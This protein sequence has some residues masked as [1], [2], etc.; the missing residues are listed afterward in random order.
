MARKFLYL[1]AILIALFVAAGLVFQLAPDKV[2][3]LAFVPSKPF[4]AP[5]ALPANRYADQKLWFARPGLASDPL[6][7]EP[8]GAKPA[9]P[10]KAAVFFIH[11]TSYLARADWNAPLDD[12]ESQDRARLFLRGLASPLGNAVQ[13]WAPRYRQAA[14]GAFFTDGPEGK[15]ALDAAYADVLAAFDQFLAEAPADLPIVLAGHSQ[16]GFHLR[17]LLAERVADQPIARRIAAVYAVGW[18]VSAEHDLPRMGLPACTAPDQSGCVASWLSYG[19]PYDAAQMAG[20]MA[21]YQGLD[22]QSL[23]GGRF[24]CWNPLT[25][26]LD[27]NAPAS[28]NLGTLVPTSDLKDGEIKPGYTPAGC[29]KDGTL[30]LGGTPKM[31]PYVLPGNNYHVYDMPLFWENLRADYARRVAAW[32]SKH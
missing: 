26:T 13:V 28:A 20:A 31:G 30:S 4:A 9:A 23:K 21:R 6:H 14:F 3:R 2:M 16:G 17:R 22:G 5:L 12:G 29:R 18:P 32:Q 11:P 10:V 8:K 24:L 25:G 1:V 27:T 7:W 15:Q 19:E